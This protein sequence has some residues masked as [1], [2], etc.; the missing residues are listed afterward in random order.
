MRVAALAAEGGEDVEGLGVVG[1]EDD[2][3][4]GGGVDV[5]E[6]AG[7]ECI[8]SWEGY[9]NFRTASIGRNKRECNLNHS[10]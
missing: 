10:D 9:L 6:H 2:F 8:S 7:V 4:G 3:V 5:G 1:Y